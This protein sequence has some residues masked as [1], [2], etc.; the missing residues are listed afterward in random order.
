MRRALSFTVDLDD[1]SPFSGK[2]V[3][4]G[5]LRD[6]TEEVDGLEAEMETIVL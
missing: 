6:E 5:W 1:W 4:D 3:T 2:D